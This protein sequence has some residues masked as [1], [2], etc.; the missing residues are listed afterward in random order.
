M[1]QLPRYEQ[2]TTMSSEIQEFK[3]IPK[4]SAVT[5]ST[6]KRAMAMALMSEHCLDIVQGKEVAPKAL[7]ALLDDSAP[8]AEAVNEYHQ[9]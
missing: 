9:V 2:T 7:T 4:L 6:W 3:G 1:K 5:Y 8:T